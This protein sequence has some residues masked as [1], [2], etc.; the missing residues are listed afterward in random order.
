MGIC[1]GRTVIITGAGGGLG[2][3]YALTYAAEGAAVVVNDI[4]R[5]A[6]QAVCDEIARAGG[7]ALGNADD[8]TRID[9]AQRIVDAAHEAFGEVH[10]LVNNAGIC[11][12]R[13]FASM[14]EDDWDDVMRVHLRGHF[15]L[16]QL[17]AREWRE[18]SKAGAA[19]DARIINTSSGAGL[20]GSIGQANYG[21]AKAAIAALTLMQAA[22]LQRYGIRVNALAPAAR[23]SMTEGVFADV[24]KKPA[25]GFDYF[26]P[27]NVAP[28][29]V[30]LGSEHSRD[31]TGQV[32]EAAGGM[33]A[34]AEGWRTGPRIDHGARWNVAEIGGAVAALIAQREPAQRVYGS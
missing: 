15:C 24:M 31:V 5:D 2:R 32:F 33:I 28:L 25:D 10:V 18:A 6:A 11:R 22:E 26:D 14:T 7:R 9:T 13:M 34:V 21:A 30:W 23:T 27:A 4:R 16:A 1:N 12:D 20:Q 17:L 8:I 19:V 3:E 29:V